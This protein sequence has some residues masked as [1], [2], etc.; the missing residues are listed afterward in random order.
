MLENEMQRANQQMIKPV[1]MSI[2]TVMPQIKEVSRITTSVVLY[3]NPIAIHRVYVKCNRENVSQ[4]AKKLEKA[5]IRM[6]NNTKKMIKS[7]CCGRYENAKKYAKRQAIQAKKVNVAR[8]RY[9]KAYNR[10]G[11]ADK[12]KNNVKNSIKST[13][14]RKTSSLLSNNKSV[15]LLGKNKKTVSPLGNNATKSL[16]TSAKAPFGIAKVGKQATDSI[17][18]GSKAAIKSYAKSQTIAKTV[19]EGDAEAITYKLGATGTRLF[20]QSAVRLMKLVLKAAMQ[21]FKLIAKLLGPLSL[22]IF[23]PVFLV[24]FLAAIESEKGNKE[25]VEEKQL[26]IPGNYEYVS[27]SQTK[28]EKMYVN[29]QGQREYGWCGIT[30]YADALATIG[31]KNSSG[32]RITPLDIRRSGSEYIAVSGWCKSYIENN[33]PD[34]SYD[35]TNGY[36]LEWIDA[37]LAEG[38]MVGIYLSPR[39]KWKKNYLNIS[40]V[41]SSAHWILIVGKVGNTE[42]ACLDPANGTGDSRFVKE[43]NAE[44]GIVGELT[45]DLSSIKNY[46]PLA[47]DPDIRIHSGDSGGSADGKPRANY[48]PPA[49]AIGVNGSVPSPEGSYIIYTN[50]THISGDIYEDAQGNTYKDL[51]EYLITGYC[52]CPQC[53]GGW[54]DGITATGVTAKANHTIAVDPSIISYGSKVVIKNI[55]YTA[56]DCGGAIKNKHIDMYFDTHQEALNW[57]KRYHH[58]Y[59]KQ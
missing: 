35:Y 59:I 32:N 12:L 34:V 40:K 11:Y 18:M 50:L 24:I 22:I 13:V 49:F 3:V 9:D 17:N 57:G 30:A 52:P 47:N 28:Y 54:S 43:E 19:M 4:K 29:S 38:K 41:T 7:V 48:N 36:T 14:N 1:Q 46:S 51:G 27:Y 26:L 21:V 25:Q 8:N 53:C 31:C 39:A 16:S 20:V 23:I 5:T 15:S 10:L 42:Y 2:E 55:E 37:R 33:Y 44:K 45:I 58:V 56:E 6:N